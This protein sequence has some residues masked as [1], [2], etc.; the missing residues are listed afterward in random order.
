MSVPS[1]SISQISLDSKLSACPLCQ[2]KNIKYYDHDFN[3]INIDRCCECLTQ[4]MNPQY[5]DE[6]QSNL[7]DGYSGITESIEV[8]NDLI[9]AHLN[10]H[11]LHFN[12]IEKYVKPSKILA[13]GCGNGLEIQVARER[14]W[15]VEGFDIDEDSILKLRDRYHSTIHTGN[16]FNLKLIEKSFDCI[17]LDQV[18][19]H[20]KSPGCYLAEFSRLLKPDGI[21]FLASPN[22]RSISSIWK[23][24]LGRLGLKRR[25]CK[26]YDT[27]HHLFYFNPKSLS[28]LLTK[29]YN[30]EV[31]HKDNDVF[32]LPDNNKFKSLFLKM[33][34]KVPLMWR[35][36]FY[37][38][39]RNSIN[40]EIYN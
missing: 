23:T 17:Y 18:L 10:C 29:K 30:F 27:W 26:H 15:E 11:Q 9:E 40:H 38:I 19:E 13:F 39:A 2:S 5:C 20:L 8:T 4:F 28:A 1:L 16:F 34:P 12:E 35:S 31:L 3:G 24:L 33:M 6:H 25:R 37:L 36:T 32:I 7:Y 22:I 14:G 21:L